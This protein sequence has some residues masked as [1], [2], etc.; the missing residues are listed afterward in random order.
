MLDAV[1]DYLPSPADIPT[2]QVS[3]PGNP[4]N[5]FE[6]QRQDDAPLADRHLRLLP[7]RMLAVLLMSAFTC[8]LARGRLYRTAPKVKKNASVA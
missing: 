5:Q 3:E 2:V 1:I 4:E 6:L 7:I 8:A